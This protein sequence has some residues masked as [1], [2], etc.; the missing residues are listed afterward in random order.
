MTSPKEEIE[1]VPTV[2][3]VSEIGKEPELIT[4]VHFTGEQWNRAIRNVQPLDPDHSLDQFGSGGLRYERLQG[5]R[6]DVLVSPRSRSCAGKGGEDVICVPVPRRVKGPM[7]V[8]ECECFAGSGEKRKR[9]PRPN[10]PECEVVYNLDEESFE[11]R[12]ERCDRCVAFGY[13]RNYWFGAINCECV[14]LE[15]SGVPSKPPTP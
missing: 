4:H 5:A 11:C 9:Q 10:P 1:P 2:R 3:N 8:W 14:Q 7:L 12:S 15:S 6:G 13:S